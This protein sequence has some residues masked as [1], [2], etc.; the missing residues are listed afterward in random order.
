MPLF[1]RKAA[2]RRVSASDGSRSWEYKGTLAQIKVHQ[3]PGAQ[4]MKRVGT[5]AGTL[6]KYGPGR[7]RGNEDMKTRNMPRDARLVTRMKPE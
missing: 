6:L 5:N 7:M 3:L 2:R 4:G 1:V